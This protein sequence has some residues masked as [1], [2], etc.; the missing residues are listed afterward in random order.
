MRTRYK[1]WFKFAEESV[2]SE[3][4]VF[5]SIA[6]ARAATRLNPTEAA[7]TADDEWELARSG[8]YVLAQ[9]LREEMGR[10]SS[11]W[12]IEQVQVPETDT[13]R[14]TLAIALGFEYGGIDG[15]DHKMWTIDQMLRIL[16]GDSYE[17][18]VIE[19]NSGEDGPETYEWDEGIAP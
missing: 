9:R 18:L 1:V 15:G 11:P 7:Y 5:S 3:S 13:D 16:A 2:Y 12:K 4:G 8:D 19:Y 17:Q 10:R 14:I 6:E